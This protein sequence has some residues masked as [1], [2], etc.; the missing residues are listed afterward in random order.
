M[1]IVEL[2]PNLAYKNSDDKREGESVKK[3]LVDFYGGCRR[4]PH[5]SILAE[6]F[7]KIPDILF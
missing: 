5:Q 1:I 6:D 3:Y 4:L 7:P 2:S